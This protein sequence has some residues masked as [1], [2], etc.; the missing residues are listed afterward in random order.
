[1]LQFRFSE[2]RCFWVR[3]Q[4][5][6]QGPRPLKRREKEENGA[7]EDE[8]QWTLTM[9]R[10]PLSQRS[11]E[12]V[13]CIHQKE[14]SLYIPHRLVT[15]SPRNGSSVVKVDFEAPMTRHSPHSLHSPHRWAA[16]PS[17][18]WSSRLSISHTLTSHKDE[19]N[20]QHSFLKEILSPK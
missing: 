8:L 17:L 14:P 12:Q 10:Q 18:I 2:S 19:N 6:F 11:L 13:S 16:S 5:V 9:L 4:D 20:S 7:E 15:M 3:G 1:M